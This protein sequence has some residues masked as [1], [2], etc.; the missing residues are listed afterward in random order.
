MW[1]DVA[2]RTDANL[3]PYAGVY[4][5]GGNTF[6]LLHTL[7][8]T[9]FMGVLRRF[10]ERGGIVYGGSAGA[11]ILGRDIM[12]AAHLDVNEV[13]L[14]DTEGLNLLDD[15]SVSCHYQPADDTR[16][17]A[18][19]ARSSFSVIALSERSGVFVRNRRV[20]ALGSE[21]TIV[22]QADSRQTYTPASII[23]L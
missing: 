1:T 14:Q 5:G 12:T 13:G 8:S 3:Q 23:I 11:N 22:F 16:I 21:P 10:I 4:I 9:G 6:K 20:M 17:H 15:Y 7:K 18:Y 19:I 2:N